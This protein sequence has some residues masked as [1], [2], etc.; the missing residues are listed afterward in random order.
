[1]SKYD[2]YYNGIDNKL[3][4][5]DSFLTE[6]EIATR[7]EDSKSGTSITID[8]TGCERIYPKVVI[9]NEV[10]NGIIISSPIQISVD[11]QIDATEVILDFENQQYTADGNNII[12]IISFDDNERLYIEENEE[13]T[14][15]LSV[16]SEVNYYYYP[17]Q[18]R[19]RFV[20]SFQIDG[21]VEFNASRTKKIENNYN[22][23]LSQYKVFDSNILDNIKNGDIFRIKFRNVELENYQTEEQYLLEVTIDDWDEGF[24]RV[25]DIIVKNIS[26]EAQQLI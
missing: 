15:D 8:N 7:V 2:E 16:L 18:Q 11:E 22:F 10:L 21:E 14:I 3:N 13:V 26:G 1:V 12:D 24:G 19:E 23:S 4:I 17:E 9:T 5:Y 20:E 25:G 6:I